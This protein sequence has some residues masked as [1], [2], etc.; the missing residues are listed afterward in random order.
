MTQTEKVRARVV[1]PRTVAG[2][3]PGGVVELDPGQVNVSA[4]VE[5]GHI[6][7]LAAKARPAGGEVAG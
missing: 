7:L 4:L 5:A 2:V 6:K 3:A 1:G